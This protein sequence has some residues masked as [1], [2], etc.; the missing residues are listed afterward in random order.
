M[1][2]ENARRASTYR[3]SLGNFLASVMES[4]VISAPSDWIHRF[5][6]CLSRPDF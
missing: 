1:K 5:V 4:V 6:D 2:T 3:S